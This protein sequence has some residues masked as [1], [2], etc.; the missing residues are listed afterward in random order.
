MSY[1]IITPTK[2]REFVELLLTQKSPNIESY[3]D[4]SNDG[5]VDLTAVLA[6]STIQEGK[7][8]TAINGKKP[9]EKDRW[10]LEARMAGPIHSTLRDLDPVVLSD[11]GLWRFLALGPFLWYLKAREPEL[12]AQDYGGGWRTNAAGRRVRTPFRSQLIFR[13]FLWGKIAF[14]PSNPTDPY[15]LTT[16]VGEKNGSEIDIWHSHLIRIQL[17]HLGEMPRAFLESITT[18]PRAIETDEARFVEKRLTRLKH[19]LLF[20]IYDRPEA[21][22]LANEVKGSLK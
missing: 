7:W 20:D 15:R 1:P 17:G 5:D 10:R 18:Q 6:T 22:V 11:E 4:D 12:Q 2:A 9:T 8:G 14:D 3:V 13:T 16:I 19:S 21:I